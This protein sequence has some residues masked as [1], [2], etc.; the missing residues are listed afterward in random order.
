V[1]ITRDI[2]RNTRGFSIGDIAAFSPGVTFVQ[3]NGPRDVSISIRGS[4]ARTPFGIRNIQLF[5]DGFPVTQPD[6]TSRTDAADPHVYGAID[7]VRGPSSALYGNYATGG[8]INL[9]TRSGGEVAG[10]EAGFDGGSFDTR[11]FYGMFGHKATRFE[12][13]A[14]ASQS[15]GNRHTSHT[16]YSTTTENLLATYTPTDTD[17]FTFKFL[18]NDLSTDLSIRLSLNQYN[19]NPFQR[20]CAALESPGCASVSLLVNGFNGARVNV[21]PEQAGL[22]RQFVRRTIV[23]ARWERRIAQRTAWRTQFVF[24][25]RDLKEPTGATAVVNN[26]PAFNVTSD[27]TR[28]STV[29][30]RRATHF[31]GVFFNRQDT[32]SYNYNVTPAGNGTLGGLVSS[33]VGDHTNAGVRAREEVT[34]N[35]RWTGVAGVGIERTALEGTNTA[36]GYPAIG[37]PTTDRTPVARSFGNVAPEATIFYRP[38]NAWRIHA[39]VAAAYGTPQL[40]NLF[41]T[42]EGVNGNNTELESQRNIGVDVGGEWTAGAALRASATWFYESFRNELVSQSPGPNLLNFTFN[43]PRS[44]HR[45]V[46]ITAD[47][48]PLPSAAPG[49][50][51]FVAYTWN[52]HEYREYLERLS[53]GTRTAVFDRAGNLIPGVTPHYLHAR[54][55]YDHPQGLLRGVGAFFEVTYRDA[56]FMDNAN[57]IKSPGYR[58]FNLNLHYDPEQLARQRRG[59]Q[60]FVELRNLTDAIYVASAAN[61]S[62]TLNPATG[63]QNPASTLMN[64]GSIWAGTP[65]SA[66]AGMRVMF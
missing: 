20:G 14:F 31:A 16:S 18:N 30:G 11:N 58:L 7:V 29:F 52:H 27:V 22:G 49:A 40:N 61:V 50:R 53:A 28:T 6:G 62:D 12:F 21:S 15:N 42:P 19:L 9:R 1:T 33:V 41:V 10:F 46:E 65:R 63:E 3:A 37:V 34:F 32:N 35:E 48:R 36:Y 60:L 13:M 5:E 25:N 43:A 47:V 44:V 59:V 57:L 55:A 26:S 45:G 23:G 64:S 54:L 39:R 24:D 4:N 51:L 38:S 66:F 56:A 2:F 8:A 17:T